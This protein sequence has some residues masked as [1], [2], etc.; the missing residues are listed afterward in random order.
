M[1]FS[2]NDFCEVAWLDDPLKVCY[3]S[4]TVFAVDFACQKLGFANVLKKSGPPI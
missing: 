3:E 1:I 2:L 4:P